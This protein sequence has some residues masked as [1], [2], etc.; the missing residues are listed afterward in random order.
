MLESKISR[1]YVLGLGLL[2][3]ATMLGIM[4]ALDA[5]LACCALVLPSLQECGRE[6]ESAAMAAQIQC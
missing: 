5:W 3:W 4:W 2:K 6:L 1:A